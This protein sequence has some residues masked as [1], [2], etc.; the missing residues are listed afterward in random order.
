MKIV[1]SVALVIVLLLPA[2][3][4]ADGEPA[5]IG[6]PIQVFANSAIVTGDTLV[7]LGPGF[8]Q[9]IMISQAD[10]APTAGT[11]SI[12]DHTAAGGGTAIF[13]HVFTTAVFAPIQICPQRAFTAGLMIDITTSADINVSVSY[14]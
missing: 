13:T 12:L 7:K 11:V 8:L 2:L 4:G 6:T 9:C 3:A 10:A 1:L 5:F 14:R